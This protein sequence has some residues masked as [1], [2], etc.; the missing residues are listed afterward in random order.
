MSLHFQLPRQLVDSNL[1]HRESVSAS[2]L[3]SCRLL[4]TAILRRTL[5]TRT[6]GM[7]VEET[8]VL[9]RTRLFRSLRSPRQAD[10][11][12]ASLPSLVP[13]APPSSGN[14][15]R[16]TSSAAASGRA[17]PAASPAS[18]I[19]AAASDSAAP[20]SETACAGLLRTGRSKL[21]TACLDAA[22]R[23][24]ASMPGISSSCSG[25]M[26]PSF[27]MVPMP[28]STSAS[29]HRFGQTVI[30]QTPKPARRA[31]PA[32]HRDSHFLALLFLALDIDLPAEQ[33]GCQ[34]HVLA[35]LADGERELRIVDD[36]FH[37]L[38]EP[39]R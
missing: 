37:V 19:S 5:R 18:A 1:L 6:F 30:D 29:S 16:C 15:S 32:R 2:N 13:T 7:I 12:S 24:S 9:Y 38:L 8:R 36:H 39:D 21:L 25:V 27:S 3:R 33:F 31:P 20:A 23:A 34:A 10:S 11:A 14:R 28:A 4:F 17:P 26:L 22:H 35:L